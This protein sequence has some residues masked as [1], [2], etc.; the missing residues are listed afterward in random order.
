VTNSRFVPDSVKTLGS[1]RRQQS[2]H[3]SPTANNG[4]LRLGADIRTGVMEV[5]YLNNRS[6][7]QFCLKLQHSQNNGI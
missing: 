2:L 4:G 1:T 6:F 7:I 3:T 5:R